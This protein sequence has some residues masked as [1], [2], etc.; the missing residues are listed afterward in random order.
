MGQGDKTMGTNYYWHESPCETC[1][2]SESLHIG[3]KSAGWNFLFQ[4]YN[5]NDLKI[6]SWTDWQA[7]LKSDKGSKGSILNEYGVV[8]TTDWLIDMIN[9]WNR[10]T[11]RNHLKE[12]PSETDKL[13]DQDNSFLFGK[14]F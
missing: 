8:V 14:F 5:K 2:R 13:D 6:E 10:S 3:K 7:F 9:Q 1:G 12:Y 11:N 4:G